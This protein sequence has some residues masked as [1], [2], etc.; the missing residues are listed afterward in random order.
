MD[1]EEVSISEP[2]QKYRPWT[3]NQLAELADKHPEF[4]EVLTDVQMASRVFP[5]RLS[6]HVIDNLIRWDDLEEDPFFHLLIPT[7]KM[8]EEGHR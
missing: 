1:A 6:S 5:F 7:M 8:L 2:F 4:S 3:R